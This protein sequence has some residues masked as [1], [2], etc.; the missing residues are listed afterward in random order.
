MS[1]LDEYLRA[2]IRRVQRKF[3]E[4]GIL[5]VAVADG[6]DEAGEPEITYMTNMDRE[7]VNSV[8]GLIGEPSAAPAGA[9]LH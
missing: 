4:A 1:S 2:T 3:P 6:P 8:V 9:V 7:E 5:F